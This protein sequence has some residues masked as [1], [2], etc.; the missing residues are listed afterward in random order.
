MLGLPVSK[1]YVSQFSAPEVGS[2]GEKVL[3]GEKPTNY[4]KAHT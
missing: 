1:A 4:S 2:G 3:E